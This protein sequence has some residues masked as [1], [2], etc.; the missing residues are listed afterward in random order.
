MML[1]FITL[2]NLMDQSLTLHRAK[3]VATELIK[4]NWNATNI[5]TRGNGYEEPEAQNQIAVGSAQN[6]RIV[7]AAPAD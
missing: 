4:S 1:S 5:T 7:M 6:R 2:R 3:W